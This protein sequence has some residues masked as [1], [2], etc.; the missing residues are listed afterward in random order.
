MYHR[1]LELFF[2][3]Y[4]ETGKWENVGYLTATFSHLIAREILTPSELE[5]LEKKG[6]EGLIGYYETY[7]GNFSSPLFL[8]YNFRQRNVFFEEIPLTGKIDK[9]IRLSDIEPIF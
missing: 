9:I 5:R 4:I 6:I 7:K 2:G 3:K 1:T 8:E